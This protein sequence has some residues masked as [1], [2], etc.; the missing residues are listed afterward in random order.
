M[1]DNDKLFG[2]DNKNGDTSIQKNVDQKPCFVTSNAQIFTNLH[3]A[4]VQNAAKVVGISSGADSINQFIINSGLSD[5]GRTVANKNDRIN[6]G[7]RFGSNQFEVGIVLELHDAKENKLTDDKTKIDDQKKKNEQMAVDAKK[8]ILKGIQ[9][10]FK[11][12]AGPDFARQITENDL[13][14]FIPDYNGGKV[15]LDG[16]EIVGLD[17]EKEMKRLKRQNKE[18][19]ENAINTRIGF[20]VGYTINYGK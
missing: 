5:D 3:N 19:D 14:K 12:F 10:Y 8:T 4:A 20:K 6:T 9:E 17:I 7:R 11:W 15:Q 13:V 2:T 16:G 18:Q 1:A